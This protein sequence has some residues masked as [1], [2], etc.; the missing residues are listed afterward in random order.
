MKAAGDLKLALSHV[1][2]IGG[3]PDTGKSSLAKVIGDRFG[4]QVYSLDEHAEDH[5]ENH[6]SKNA[7]AFGHA[8]MQLSLDERWIG[9]S[10]ETQ[11]D[12][13]LR[14]EEDDFPLVID[15]LL[16]MPAQPQTVAEG[17][18][19]P[20]LL[21]PL[22]SSQQQA[23]WL[24]PTDKFKRESFYRRGKNR[25]HDERSNP[26]QALENHLLRDQLLG[27][28][29]REQALARGYKILEVDGA[30]SLDEIANMTARH[31]GII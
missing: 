20:S 28:R 15:D 26:A 2:W 23:I 18:L 16:A 4:L 13:V 29:I 25:F 11:V 8:L 5:W 27:Q 6:V 30:R 1:R 9:H 3:P 21:E 24:L 17:T 31:F 12:N 7:S 10:P 14:I 19:L 22:L